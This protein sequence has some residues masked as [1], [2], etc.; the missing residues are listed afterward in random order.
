MSELPLMTLS[1]GRSHIWNGEAPSVSS[2]MRQP[3]RRCTKVYVTSKDCGARSNPASEYVPVT[4]VAQA[5]G[6]T[7]W[8][9]V[10]ASEGA[11]C[12]A[13]Y[14]NWP[15]GSLTRLSNARDCRPRKLEP[16]RSTVA[17]HALLF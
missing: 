16:R 8:T 1:P 11:S 3:P 5:L 7:A 12:D 6:P 17:I 9:R 14:E 4:V 15:S 10:A 13:P 2:A